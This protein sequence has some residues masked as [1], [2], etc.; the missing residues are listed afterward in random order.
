MIP[1]SGGVRVYVATR[2]VDFRKGHDGLAAVVQE[3]LGLDPFCGAIFVFRS[4]RADRVKVLAWDGTGLV[5][6]HKRLEGAKFAW[7]KVADGTMRLTPG[8]FSALFEGLDWR[9]VRAER[10]PRPVSAG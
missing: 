3:T 5:L 9:T 2:P 6:A 1:V 4:K 7:P 10:R 8:Q